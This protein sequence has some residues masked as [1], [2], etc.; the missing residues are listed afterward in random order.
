MSKLLLILGLIVPLYTVPVAAETQNFA[1]LLGNNLGHDPPNKLNYAEQDVRKI[2]NALMELGGCKRDKIKLTDEVTA[3]G[4]AIVTSSGFND[5]SQ[6]STEEDEY[7]SYGVVVS[8]RLKTPSGFDPGSRV[9]WS[10]RSDTKSCKGYR[11]YG[12]AL[13]AVHAL[14][15]SFFVL[16]FQVALGYEHIILDKQGDDRV[17]SLFFT[18]TGLLGTEIHLTDTMFANLDLVVGGRVLVGS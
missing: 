13:T 11:D 3:K 16:R 8:Y 10:S 5:L 15:F 9:T 14:P 4:Y 6:K 2:P 7:N 1:V 12:L 18:Y 17:G